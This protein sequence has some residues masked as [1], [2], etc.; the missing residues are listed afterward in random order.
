MNGW[1]AGTLLGVLAVL[2]AAALVCRT[3]PGSSP[4][5]T[6]YCRRLCTA[7]PPSA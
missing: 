1:L 2:A 6:H 5:D 4:V 7:W 3:R